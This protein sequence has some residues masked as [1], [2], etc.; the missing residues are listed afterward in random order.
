MLIA[1]GEIDAALPWLARAG[2][3][4]TPAFVVKAIAWLRGTGD[5]RLAG[6]GVAAMRDGC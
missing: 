4:G 5:A 3:G 2:Q 6:E 1:A